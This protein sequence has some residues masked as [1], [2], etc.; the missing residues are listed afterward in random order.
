MTTLRICFFGDSIVHGTKDP[1]TLGWPGRACAAGVA[2]GHDVTMYNLGIRGDT[3]EGVRARWHDE[4]ERRV[5]AETSGALVFSF[6]LN[7]SLVDSDGNWRVEPNRT[8]ENIA[9]VLH[10]A[11]AW[12][13]T[14]VIGP[15]PVDDS[16]LP[17]Q[18]PGGTRW[19][20]D[21]ARIR[22]VGL[23]MGEVAIAAAIPYLDVFSRLEHDPRWRAALVG[24]DSVHPPD[25]Y[26]VIADLVTGWAAW[27]QLLA[28]APAFDAARAGR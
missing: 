13:P 2:E 8:R 15:A 28:T 25:G 7:D 11:I 20:T 17:P 1:S 23:V 6:G 5:S 21:N 3:S 12:L 26:A 14:L 10:E 22:G 24:S 19:V 18:A 16:R 4:A 9:A 27:Q